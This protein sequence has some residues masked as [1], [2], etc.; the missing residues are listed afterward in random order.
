MRSPHP[1]RCAHCG[2]DAGPSPRIATDGRVFCCGGC[3]A[4]YGILHQEGLGAFYEAGGVGSLASRRPPD[5]SGGARPGPA[6]PAL[7]AAGA[8]ELDVVGMRCASCAWLIERYVGRRE[9]VRD[10]Q[11]SYATATATLHWDPAR[12]TLDQLFGSLERIGYRARPADPR[13]R[14]LQEEREGRVLFVRTGIALFLAMNVT[15]AS[16]GLYAGEWQGM[17]APVRDLLRVLAGLLALP[18]VLWAGWPF[19]R[20]ALTALRAGRAT[21]DS[22]VAVGSWTAFS[23]SLAGMATGGPVYFDSAAMIVALVLA[24]RAVE[25]GARRRGTQAVRSLLALEPTS[26]RLADGCGVVAAADLAAG[27][28]VEVRPGERFPCDG[29]V[30]TGRSEADEAL[31]TG[32]SRPREVGPGD[33]VHGGSINGWGVVR[34]RADRVGAGTAV[35]RIARAVERA[36]ASKAPLERLADRVTGVFVP[37]VLV[38]AALTAVGWWLVTRDPGRAVM[39]GVAAV[40]IAC[41]CAL[42]LATPA[43]LVIALGGAARRGIFFRDAD[44]LERAA[45]VTRVAFDKTGTLTD[46]ALGLRAVLPTGLWT[47]EGLLKGAA[48]AELPS[49]HAVGRALVAE[50]R[51][52][53]LSL[54]EP[55]GFRAFPGRGVEAWTSQGPVLVG[56]RAFLAGRGAATGPEDECATAAHVAVDGVYAGALLVGDA[57]RPEAREAV[58]RLAALGVDAAVVSGDAVAPV[59]RSA[60]E[61]GVPAPHVHHGLAPEEK[62]RLLSGW[63]QEGVVAAM[64]GDGVNDA[65]A[66]A[67][68]GVGIALGTGTDVAIETAGIALSGSDLRSVADVVAIARRARRVVRQN[69]GWALGYNLAAIPLAMAGLIHPAVAAGAMAFSSVS[70]VL[71]ALRA[72]PRAA[73]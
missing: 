54:E 57:V 28:A 66:L 9:G 42:G 11:V 51:A 41:P 50:A 13:L 49:E 59:R 43:A 39:T 34:V 20:G 24:G 35:A 48:T 21:M 27:Q 47:E 73:A 5:A 45:A 25:H 40:V 10:V 33:L 14:S 3:E 67:A 62:A 63:A 7:E 2:L 30:L 16:I 53:G 64:V 4:V 37:A 1:S 19:L 72:A 58:A 17:G 46:A 71:N 32:E 69:L 29:T 55:T 18:V 56:S 6:F 23:A 26:A 52:R 12:T 65:P 70:V 31:L 61:A 22:L 38:L 8:A 36:L 68:A 60:A 15:L 44:A